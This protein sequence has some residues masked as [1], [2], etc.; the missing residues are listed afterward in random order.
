M[1]YRPRQYLQLRFVDS[2]AVS[3]K[4]LGLN[5]SA[6]DKKKHPV[7]LELHFADLETID[8]PCRAHKEKTPE[9]IR[10]GKRSEPHGRRLTRIGIWGEDRVE[11]AR[12]WRRFSARRTSIGR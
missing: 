1:R 12:P 7:W 6:C 2:V 4:N 11:V 5:V 10:G 8:E 3:N 9:G